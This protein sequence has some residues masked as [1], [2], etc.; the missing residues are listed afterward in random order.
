MLDDKMKRI[1][2]IHLGR[3]SATTSLILGGRGQKADTTC[4]KGTRGMIN[5]TLYLVLGVSGS[6]ASRQKRQ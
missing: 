3:L 1:N 4:S 2:P 5:R 6:E